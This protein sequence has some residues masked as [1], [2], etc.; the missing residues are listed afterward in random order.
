M[1]KRKKNK[2]I[3]QKITLKIKK[4]EN[5]KVHEYKKA[6]HQTWNSTQFHFTRIQIVFISSNG[7]IHSTHSD[8]WW[9]RR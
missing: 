9:R 8:L 5:M 4:R 2:Y 3:L 1:A 6:N 7:F